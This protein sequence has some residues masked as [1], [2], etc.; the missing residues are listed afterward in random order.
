MNVPIRKNVE[1][2]WLHSGGIFPW[3]MLGPTTALRC[4]HEHEVVAPTDG[5]LWDLAWDNLLQC[6]QAPDL[7]REFQMVL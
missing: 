5:F 4:D 3:R 7:W 6:A 2:L 1:K